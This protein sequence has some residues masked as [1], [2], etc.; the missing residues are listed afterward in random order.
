MTLSRELL[1]ILDANANRLKEGLR[2]V[3]EYFRFVKEDAPSVHVC[4]TLRHRVSQHLELCPQI[5]REELLGARAVST[6][7]LHD[8]MSETEGR[9]EHLEAVRL[10]N[11]QRVKESLRVL[12]EYGKLVSAEWGLFFQT[13]RFEWYQFEKD[14]QGV[15]K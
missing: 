1:R 4:K 8:Q 13:I 5:T 15:T 14:S 11:M 7:C 2:V 10:A 3:E 12:E 9:R 6:D